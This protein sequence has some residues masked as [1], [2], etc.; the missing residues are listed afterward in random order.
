MTVSE[1]PPSATSATRRLF[2][3]VHP[4][5]DTEDAPA[6]VTAA[7]GLVAA[8]LVALS[9]LSAI[10]AGYAAVGVGFLAAVVVF[11]GTL[12]AFEAGRRLGA[13]D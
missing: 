12:A 8:V 3:Y 2:E 11:V 1:D 13:G 4:G 9:T 10:E 7:L 5:E 6:F